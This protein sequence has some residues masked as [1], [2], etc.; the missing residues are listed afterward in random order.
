[1]LVTLSL[2]AILAGMALLTLPGF[3]RSADLD[4]EA[5]RLEQLLHAARRDARLDSLDYGLR[6]TD[7]GYELLGF[8]DAQQRWVP[9]H[10][11]RLPDGISLH[12]EADAD[13][14][15]LED[16]SLPPALIL[17]SGEMTPFVLRLEADGASRLLRADGYGRL[18]WDPDE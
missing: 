1:M 15:Q 11:V 17:S 8:D 9:V 14:L 18:A 12:L 3:V 16:A 7:G 5:R 2:V 10:E 13:W 6:P 4:A